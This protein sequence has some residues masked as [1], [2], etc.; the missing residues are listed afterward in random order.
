[1]CATEHV[2][3]LRVLSGAGRLE[4]QA[5]GGLAYNNSGPPFTVGHLHMQHTMCVQQ[6]LKYKW[7]CAHCDRPPV[8]YTYTL[9]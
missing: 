6:L 4:S 2:T 3:N 9:A 8:K 1:M 5:G 7:R